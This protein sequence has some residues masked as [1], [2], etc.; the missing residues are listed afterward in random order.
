[1]KINLKFLLVP[2]LLLVSCLTSAQNIPTRPN[3]P[4]LVND[5]AGIL[6]PDE[7]QRLERQLV[8]YDDST[9]NQ[10]AIVLLNTLDDY[11]I[12]E[13]ALRLFRDW[14]IG[15]KKTN[16]GVLIL[17]ALQDR[18]IRIE[19]GYGLEGAIPDITAN[20]IIQGDIAPNFRSNDY[21]EGLSKAA[22]SII[23]AAA[24]E[25]KAPAN[26]RKRKGGGSAF[27]FGALV[28]I[29]ILLVLFGGRNRGGG[30]GF[31]SRRGS[32]WLG[33]FI[34]GNMMG[35]SSGGSSWGGGGGGW[36][37]GGGGFGGFGGGSSGGGGA[38]GSW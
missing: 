36:S 25:Y 9:S 1:M 15:N 17:A 4:R 5:F 35:R 23:K 2:A 37:G 8:A 27:P 18:K 34:L 7:E 30:G 32:G 31:M 33:P 13:F 12:E 11:P 22:N 26:Y 38:S 28:F 19:V 29:I 6:S 16:N 21:Y 24:G 14:G 10:V 3:P 20:H